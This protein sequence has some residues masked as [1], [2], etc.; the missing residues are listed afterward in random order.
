MHSPRNQTRSVSRWWWCSADQMP[1]RVSQREPA[2]ETLILAWCTSMLPLQRAF[3]VKGES[4]E[5]NSLEHIKFWDE[6]PL[7]HT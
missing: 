1:L 2:N 4:T 7:Q 3:L 6:F 5:S